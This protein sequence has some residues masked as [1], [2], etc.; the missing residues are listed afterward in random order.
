[1][2]ALQCTTAGPYNALPFTLLGFGSV[3]GLSP[4][5]VGIHFISLAARHRVAACST[6]LAEA[7]RRSIRLVDTIALLFARSP[8]WDKEFLVPSMANS[9]A[10]ALWY[11]LSFGP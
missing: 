1:M 6:T 7:L 10:D 11:C 4:E 8:I 3:C 9:T 5:L 2:H